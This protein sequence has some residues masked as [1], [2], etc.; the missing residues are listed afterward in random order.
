MVLSKIHLALLS[1]AGINAAVIIQILAE[2]LIL[3]QVCT[4]MSKTSRP[5]SEDLLC[6][7]NQFIEPGGHSTIF[8]EC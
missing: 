3:I 8:C 1:S 7:I 6:T 5:F 4:I 2:I